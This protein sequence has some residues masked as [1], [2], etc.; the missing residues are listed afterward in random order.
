MCRPTAVGA[1]RAPLAREHLGA[2]FRLDVAQGTAERRLREPAPFGHGGQGAGRG[3]LAQQ[4]QI[5]KPQPG[6]RN[7][8]A[9]GG[10]VHCG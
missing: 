5:A 7:R 1:S 10:I 8:V 9:R 2:Q 4:L 6:K 3:D